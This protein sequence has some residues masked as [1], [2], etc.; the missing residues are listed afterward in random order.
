[1]KRKPLVISDPNQYGSRGQ[2]WHPDFVQYMVEIYKSPAYTG[3]PDA[4]KDDGKIQWEAPSNRSG[5]IYQY[6]HQ[7]RATWWRNKA[8][9]TG[10]NLRSSTWISDTA[11]KI[12]PFG[13]KPCK[14]CGR[15]MRI[16]YSYPNAHI[17]RRL[18]SLY[19]GAV[20]FL[21]QPSTI[22]VYI[23]PSFFKFINSTCCI[24]I[25][26]LTCKERVTFRTNLNMNLG[27]C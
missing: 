6:T 24:N 10:I 8:K 2:S 3:M 4:I 23:V 17:K 7:K 26:H 5:G 19:S 21:P 14:R 15:V 20:E 11:K 13:E 22:L 9:Q 25:P 16:A 18:Q 27:K 12:H 1:M